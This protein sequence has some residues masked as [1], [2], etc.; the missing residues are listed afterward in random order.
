MEI[1]LAFFVG[2]LIGAGVTYF[3]RPHGDKTDNGAVEYLKQELATVRRE[4]ADLIGRIAAAN[5]Q[6][7]TLEHVR[8]EML[9][10]FKNVSAEL[11]EMSRKSA[12]EQQT[13][14]FDITITPF[15]ERLEKMTADFNTQIKEMLK[16]TTEN[17]TSIQ[18]QLK[19][20][21][22]SSSS[23]QKEAAD[24]TEALRGKKKLQGNWGEIQVE[25]LFEILGW[26][27]GVQYDVQKHL[28]DNRDIPDYIVHMPG[29]K[30]FVVD[31]KMSLNSYMDYLATDDDA[32]KS[33]LWRA[34]VDA[35]K[36]HISELGNKNY[37]MVVDKKFDYV[38]MFMPL[39]HAYI[40]LMNR[41]KEIYKYAYDN[42]VAIATPSLLLPMLRT[43]DTLMKIEKQNQNVGRV[44]EMAENLYNKYAAFS[45]EYKKIGGAIESLQNVYNDSY[46]KLTGRGGMASLLEKMKKQGGLTNVKT[47]ALEVNDTDMDDDDE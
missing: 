44:V 42:G 28:S 39:E 3:M 31:A 37:N 22:A 20:M 40:E 11:L 15:K 8:G 17:R 19:N 18:E 45:V 33:K 12:V 25:R 24:L 38:C 14:N 47:P 21:M 23:L 30:H 10:E 1:A 9:A 43:I 35:T 26:Q 7:K 32:E 2:L 4:N 34:F 36:K 27:V 6:I 29:D 5:T 13:K 46:K 41:D 16:N